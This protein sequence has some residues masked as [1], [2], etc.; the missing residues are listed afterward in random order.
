MTLAEQI[1]DRSDI[2]RHFTSTTP[3]YPKMSII[4]ESNSPKRPG[5]N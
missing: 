4:M 3:I 1:S 5:E 2:C